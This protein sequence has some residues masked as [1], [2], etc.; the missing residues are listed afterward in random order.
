[1]RSKAP[2]FTYYVE[3]F[4]LTDSKQLGRNYIFNYIKLIGYEVQER[5]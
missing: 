5:L 1:M 2:V 4:A 3:D